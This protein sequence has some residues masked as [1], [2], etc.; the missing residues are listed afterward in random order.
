MKRGHSPT[1]FGQRQEYLGRKYTA[2]MINKFSLEVIHRNFFYDSGDLIV[3]DANKDNFRSGGSDPIVAG[4]LA[5]A[6]N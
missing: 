3:R 6:Y 1:F 5:L 4:G 2:G